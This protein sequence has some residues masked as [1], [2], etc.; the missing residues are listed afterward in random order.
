[1]VQQLLTDLH[2]AEYKSMTAPLWPLMNRSRPQRHALPVR[3]HT[4]HLH[5]HFSKNQS[6]IL[7]SVL[8]SLVLFQ[9]LGT[10]VCDTS[11]CNCE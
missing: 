5:D 2:G 8:R 11:L 6:T 4:E 1:M 9:I 7:D 10:G 3:P